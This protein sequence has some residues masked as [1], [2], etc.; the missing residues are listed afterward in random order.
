MFWAVL[1]EGTRNSEVSLPLVVVSVLT[2][3]ELPASEVRGA[4]DRVTPKA[5]QAAPLA[6]D[7]QE[8]P[9]CPMLTGIM[10]QQEVVEEAAD[11]EE[12][13]ETTVGMVVLESPF[14]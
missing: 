2:R 9:A 13:R 3:M 8:G 14:Q 11:L 5:V 4:E 1:T 12:M 10:R 6:K 7:F